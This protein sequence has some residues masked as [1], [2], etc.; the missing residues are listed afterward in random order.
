MYK[1]C[2]NLNIQLGGDR[3]NTFWYFTIVEYYTTTNIGY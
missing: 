3:V 2:N 1:V